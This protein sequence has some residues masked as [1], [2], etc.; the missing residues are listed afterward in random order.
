MSYAIVRNEKLTRDEAKGRYVHNERRTRG[1]TNKDIDPERTHLNYYF[2]KNELSYIKEFDKLRKEKDLKG[3]IKSN[4]IIL[5]EMIFTSDKKFFDDIGE[6]ETKRYFEESY[7]FICNYKKLGEENIISAVVHL[8]EAVPHMHLI[9]TPVVHTKDKEGN[10]IDKICARDF[11]KGRDSYRN[12]QNEFYNYIT[13]KSFKLKRGMPVEETGARNLRIEELKQITNY[14]KTKQVLNK[15]NYEL[16]KVPELADIS[17][18]S[19][20]RDE[21]ILEEIIKPKDDI[22][23]ELYN[24]NL[25]LHRELSKQSRVI[26]EA[27]KY[28]KERDAIIVDNK[29][30]NNR[31]KELENEY[32]G[33]SI[34]LDL[35][36]DNRK[37]EL[38]KEFQEKTYDLEY[39]YK[40]KV[41]KLEKENSKL[42]RIIDK[43]YETIE[44]FIHWICEKFDMG[45]EDNLIRDFQKETNTFL[46]PEKQMKKEEREMEWD[47]ER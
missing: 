30:L 7:K 38:E 12:F 35:K 34:T 46:D 24:D 36:F 5:C 29:E 23:K 27:E 2:K 10:D 39:E 1:H 33:K 47:L 28:Q 9:F 15:I 40:N 17:K 19:I 18:F 32:K 22:I 37:R 45:A 6:Q 43:F 41:R 42:H 25:A 44:R 16:P 21:K 13:E 31:V 20:K 11:W 8:D 4:S 26:K 3:H 14:E